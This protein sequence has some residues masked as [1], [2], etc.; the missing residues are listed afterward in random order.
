MRF[1]FRNTTLHII[2]ALLIGLGAGLAYSWLISPVTYVDASPAIL[3]VDFKDQ[4]R[5]VIAASYASTHDL[6]RARARLVLL[7]DVDSIGELSAQA[8]R[9]LASGEPFESVRPLAQ[10]ATDL[11]QGFASV[12][13]TNVPPPIQSTN[14]PT[15]GT[16]LPETPFIQT[17]LPSETFVFEAEPTLSFEQTLVVPQGP[18]ST[19]TPRPTSPPN[20][21]AGD[22]FTLVG[23]DT[24]CDP[25][26]KEG[27]LQ[28][29]LMDARRRQVPGIEI[30]VTW[31]QGEDHFFTGLKP[32]LGNGYADFKMKAETVYSIRVVEG[33]SFVPNIT[34]PACTDPNG[35]NYTGGLLLTFQQP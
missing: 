3:R 20:P 32:E 31:N 13:I 23:Q 33:G 35:A 6:P 19:S 27:L 2:L 12:A 16:I 26:I 4:Y 34:A 29:I 24:V 8:Q 25:S 1:D 14:T 28:V 15:A 9:M 7:G 30:I 10:L 22:P 5:N 18:L 21:S 11:Q 17:P